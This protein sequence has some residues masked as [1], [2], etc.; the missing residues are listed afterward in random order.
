MNLSELKTKLGELRALPQETE[1]VEFKSS[2][3]NKEDIGEY[4]SGL[5]NSAALLGKP[6][7]YIVWGVADGS[8]DVIGT[9]FR[10]RQTKGKGNEDLELW[11]GIHLKPRIDFRIHEFEEA[12]THVVLFEVP[13]A[14]GTPV[15][16]QGERYIRVGSHKKKLR[17]YPEKEISLF[18]VLAASGIDWSAEIIETADLDC[19]DP[20]AITFARAQYAEKHPMLADELSGWDEAKFLDKARICIGG[21]ITRTAMILL[22]KE[23]HS[24][25]LAPAQ[26]RLT[27]VLKDADGIE[28][29]YEHFDTPLLFAGERLLSKVRNLTVRHL[30]SGTLFPHAVSQYD[31]WVIRETLHNCIA[32]QDYP[33]GGRITAVETPEALLFTNLGSFIPG[34]VEEMIE[35]ETPP[36]IY[37]NPFLSRAMVNLNMIDTIGSGIRRMFTTQKKRSFPMPDFVLDDPAKVSVRLSGQVIDENYTKVL[38]N[39]SDLNLMDVIALDRVQK[40][41]PLTEEAF[42]H[43][44]RL[45]LIEGRR[46]NLY[47]SATV[48]A[49][50]GDKAAYIKNRGLDKEHYKELVKLHLEKFGATTRADLED[51]LREKI[52]D[53][54]SEEQKAN[55]IRNLL[56]EMR[57]DGAIT[58]NRRGQGARWQLTKSG[59][60]SSDLADS[61]SDEDQ[62]S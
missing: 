9:Q 25:L 34:T 48:A 29:D 58:P 47:V 55:R 13:A 27:W 28:Q 22:G 23:E 53:A 39:Q 14:K 54:L 62:G 45:K 26:P 17:D 12:G 43:L 10:P 7:G 44:K 56:Q 15:D 42:K 30:P 4:I 2:W 60:K 11:L 31:P 6:H 59:E 8:H 52:S 32:H 49:L 18:T 33:A 38:L 21:K 37:R 3:D 5:S 41:L 24:H 46:P 1:W 36:E 40:N 61:E 19:L 20:K 35:R 16:F 51:F 50:T 57:R